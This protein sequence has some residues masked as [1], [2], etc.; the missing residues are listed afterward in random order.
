MRDIAVLIKNATNGLTYIT[1]DLQTD[2][3]TNL[4][5]IS[6]INKEAAL[7][8]QVINQHSYN[9][10]KGQQIFAQYV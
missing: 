2:I 9:L 5:N 8:H 7:L 6:L 4:H 10:R 1:G 3:S